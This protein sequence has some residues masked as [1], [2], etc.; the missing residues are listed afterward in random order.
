MAKKISFSHSKMGLYKECPQKYKFR[1]VWKLPE[2]PKYYFAF[3][4]AMHKVME[5]IYG[6]AKPPFPTLDASLKFFEKDWNSTSFKDKGYATAS[7]EAEGFIEG[8]SIIN[9]YYKKNEAAFFIPLSTEM[10]ATLDADDISLISIIDRVDYLGG[11]HVNILDYKTGKNVDREPD[12]LY[13]YQKVV[14]NSPLIKQIV[15]TKDPKT[16]EV[17]V[18]KMSFYHLPSQS[19]VTFERAPDS[20]I[21]DLWSE[22][23]RIVDHIR[24]E[25]FDPTPEESKCRWCDFK[26][27]CPVFT[28][29]EFTGIKTAKPIMTEPVFGAADALAEKIDSYGI[30][31]AE[32]KNLRKEILDEM[33]LKGF[34][35]HFGKHYKA[36][37]KETD[38]L[39]FEDKEAVINLL[40]ERDLL[41]KT[42]VPTMSTISNLLADP[43]VKEED[44]TALRA[45]AKVKKEA[46]LSFKKTEE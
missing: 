23:L 17:I 22:V 1:Y 37:F 19:E 40:R 33:K 29:V 18:D 2:E 46:E 34:N 38:A 28:G 45:M 43:N 25:K 35:Q 30:K 15:Q 27:R 11:G 7:K 3:G 5:F 13:L 26:D 21:G 6:V 16:K 39:D 36:E 41:K 44:K 24:A 20:V 4:T 8:K 12:Q 31:V 9:E 14:E 10:K 32:L 42:L